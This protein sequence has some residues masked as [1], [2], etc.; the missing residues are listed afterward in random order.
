MPRKFYK[1]PQFWTFQTFSLPDALEKIDSAGLTYVEAVTFF[2]A[3]PQLKD[4]LIGQLSPAGIETVKR[5]LASH[6]LTVESI[7]IGGDATLKSWDDQFKIAKT[8]GAK[9]VTS[10]PPLNMLDE[11]D[12]LAGSYS[13]K[14]AIHE[15]WK[16]VSKYWHP[17]SVLAALN[18]HP[19]FGVCADLGHWP[20]SGVDPM[21]AVKKLEGHIIAI[22]LKDIAEFNNTKIQ[23][24]PVGTCVVDFS[25]IFAELKRQKF[26]GPFYIERDAEDRPSNLPSVIKTI[27]YYNDQVS[28]LH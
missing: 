26:E 15:H 5:L 8:L 24:V 20:K 6:N 12:R 4:S 22:H 1:A 7:Y 21:E 9:F 11:I 14:V 25:G 28:K 19:N 16:G 3:G 18:G 10:E 17:D 13:I 2:K 27:E 23:D